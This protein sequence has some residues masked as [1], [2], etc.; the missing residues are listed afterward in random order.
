[1]EKEKSVRDIKKRQTYS[2]LNEANNA[3]LELS[4]TAA[5]PTSCQIYGL[6]QSLPHVFFYGRCISQDS[7]CFYF[8][9]LSAVPT[10]S[11]LLGEG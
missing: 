11:L 1:L 8:A 5:L 6:S 9:N 2:L 3:Y 10:I 4:G 7:S